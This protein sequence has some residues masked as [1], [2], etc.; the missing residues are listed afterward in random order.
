MLNKIVIMGRISHDQ[1]LRYTPSGKAVCSFTVAV[2]RARKKE[3]GSY[4]TD[5][6]RCVAWDSKGEFIA[7]HF[8][9]GKPIVVE[10]RMQTRDYTDKDGNKRT[11]TEIIVRDVYFTLSDGKK[12]KS[13]QQE[14]YYVP[15][16]FMPT[17]ED[18]PFE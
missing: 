1:E 17:D 12:A 4:D 6:I 7:R 5:W 2:D 13:R 11:A 9:K 15:A 16:A 10:G 14:P 18:V 3:D 8:E